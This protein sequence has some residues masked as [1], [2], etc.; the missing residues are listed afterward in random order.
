M[1][2]FG[3]S[4]PG[5][6]SNSASISAATKSSTTD[7][8]TAKRRASALRFIENHDEPRATATFPAP[9]L[10]A[11]ALATLLGTK[12]F[13]EGQFEGR[14]VRLPVFLG[15]RLNE[16][17][18]HDLLDFYGKLLKAI[19]QPVFREE[20]GSCATEQAGQTTP[21]I[22]ISWHGTGSSTKIGICCRQP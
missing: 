6:S 22:K 4:L 9:K 14:K 15:R 18:D 8:N 12:L 1:K 2:G 5:N 21:A 7:S 17:V 20:S 11:A 10:K 19:H 3:I 13:D 16:P